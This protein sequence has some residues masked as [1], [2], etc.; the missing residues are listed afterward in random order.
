M[1]FWYGPPYGGGGW[2]FPL[3][4]MLLC[5]LFFLIIGGR[6]R[7]GPYFCAFRRDSVAEERGRNKDAGMKTEQKK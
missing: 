4:G 3:I 1:C 6:F 5:I 7:H 2:V